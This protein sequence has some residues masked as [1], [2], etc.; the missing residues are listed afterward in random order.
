[1]GAINGANDISI[2]GSV[3]SVRFISY[4]R[5]LKW[6]RHN[7]IKKNTI[8]RIV[9]L[10]K[11]CGLVNFGHLTACRAGYSRRVSAPLILWWCI[12]DPGAVISVIAIWYARG[13]CAIWPIL[14]D[15]VVSRTA[16][17]SRNNAN[18][19]VP[20]GSGL[21]VTKGHMFYH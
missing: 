6:W 13:V 21:L 14:Y 16:D 4:K 20:L 5:C 1:M 15:R 3:Y 12:S 11:R 10:A 18:V 19:L 2:V 8:I 7:M 17:V 9:V